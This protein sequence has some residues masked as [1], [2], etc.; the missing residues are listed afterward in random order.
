VLDV[1]WK[2]DGKLLA[3]AGADNTIKVWDYE[4]GEQA[5]TINGHGKQ[6]TRLLFL[7][8]TSQIVTCSGDQTVRF[9][10]VDNG[11][12]VRNFSGN[13]DFLYAV[14]ASPD[15]GVVAAGGEEGIVRLYNGGNGQLLKSLLPPGV[16]T[17]VNKK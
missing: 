3:S 15:G 10:N 5:R 7:G 17:A 12:N 8:T 6:V 1:G 2:A 13:N 9:W 16:E 4:K 11:G 14:S